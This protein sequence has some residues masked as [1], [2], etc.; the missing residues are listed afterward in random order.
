VLLFF[1]LLTGCPRSTPAPPRK[2]DGPQPHFVDVAERAG[3]RFTHDNGRSERLYFI[4]S[5]PG[6]VACLDYDNDGFTDLFFV[7]SGSS[8][9]PSQVTA[10]KK[11]A[12][13]RNRGDGTFADVTAGSG[14]DSDLGF[15]HGAAVGDWN[16][17]GFADLLVTSYPH[18][19][20]FKNDGGK[21]FVDV[22]GLSDVGTTHSTGYSTSAAFGDYDNDGDLDLYICYYCSWTHK[23]DKECKNAK[24]KRDYCSPEVYSPDTHQ[25]LRNDNGVFK[26]V[27]VAS[28]VSKATGRGLAVA[29][30]DYDNDKK[31]D[32]FV[33]DDISAN[34]LWVNQGSGKFVNRATELGCAYS[35]NGSLMAGMGIAIADYDRSGFDSLFVTNFAGLPNTLFKNDGT[36][37]EDMAVASRIGPAHLKFLSFG[38]EFLDFD[39]D[40]WPDIVTANGH[41][42]E[43]VAE[44]N[45]GVTFKEPKSLYRSRGDGTFEP[46]P[47]PLLGDLTRPEV[48]RGLATLDIENDG[49]LDIVTVNQNAPAQL[50]RNTTA[51]NGHHFVAF[52]TEGTRSNREGRHARFTLTM[53]GGAKQ[54][55]TV[56]AGS[57]YLSASDRRVY[58][59]LGTSENSVRVE[60][61]WPSGGK[62]ILTDVKP[63]ET[64]RVVEGKGIVGTLPRARTR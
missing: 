9:E 46:V 47:A 18:N 10:R 16:N 23:T 26:D 44:T 36:L 4:E 11:C 42:Q 21:T 37:F 53:P 12:L 62:D 6:G 40:G 19:F 29:F 24:Q 63:D 57:S 49:R 25:L 51:G 7:Q 14:L 39:A 56:R 31:P 38:T 54:T 61:E 43:H 45:P 41:V 55:A 32:I 50:L 59:G 13:F 15:A 58:F 2:P 28:G 33:A 22:S 52:L 27:S 17:D 1:A 3:V 48:A 20:L 35:E 8:A 5:T 34:L 60:V 30:F 64:Y